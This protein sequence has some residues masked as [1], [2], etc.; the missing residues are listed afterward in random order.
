MTAR[1]ILLAFVLLFASCAPKI[2]LEV[3]RPPNLNTSGIKRIAVMPFEYPSSKHEKLAQHA[4]KTVTGKIE[5]MDY[6]TVV[7][8]AEVERLRRNG[9]S[10][11]K[12]VDA[13]LVGKLSWPS[14]WTNEK[15]WQTKDGKGR[16]TNHVAWDHRTQISV[17]YTLISARDESVIGW[18]SRTGSYDDNNSS[19]RTPSSVSN[20]K[21]VDDG[22]RFLFNDLRPHTVIEK[23]KFVKD[24][25][26]KMKA[27]LA[28][29]KAGYHKDALE[30]YLEIY[31]ESKI[32]AAAENAA[33][34]HEVLGDVQAAADL[35]QRAYDNTRDTKA[36]Q[37]LARLNKILQDKA[38]LESEYKDTPK[39][40]E[41]Q[42]NE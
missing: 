37:T 9:E 13:I 40:E 41:E 36:G 24:S 1:L 4:T 23:R 38:T 10:I 30:S 34:L 18:I 31:E 27:A 8:P 2:K 14:D 3:E 21:A 5:K 39:P 20:Y 6:F 29:V 15:R 22:L 28:R 11:E 35:M 12:S 25:N 19:S 32:L 33:I 16:V 26:A 7:E 42:T 17:T